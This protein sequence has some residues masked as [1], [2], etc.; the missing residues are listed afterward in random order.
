MIISKTLRMLSLPLFLLSSVL[1]SHAAPFTQPD[2]VLLPTSL[3]VSA[4]LVSARV[5]SAYSCQLS[6]AGGKPSYRWTVQ[7]GS[8][9]NGI[10]LN[11]ATGLISGVPAA[12]GKFSV[13]VLVSDQ[14]APVK[15]KVVQGTLRV[16]PAA[17]HIVTTALVPAATAKPYHALL[18]ATGGVAHYHWAVQSGA[19][20]D[21][22]VLGA[23]TGVI[24]GV[25]HGKGTSSFVVGVADDGEPSQRA[26]MEYQLSVATPTYGH[27]VRTADGRNRSGL[28]RRAGCA[29]W[30]RT[31]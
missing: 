20:P 6:V 19:L 5:G 17:L 13:S 14:S 18:Q 7:S 15:A 27:D 30:H 23:A 2:T 24:E 16:A 4:K 31:L 12:A 8:L 1:S 25:P 28:C 26:S 9:P 21:G 10:S 3:T 11:A 22:L 29:G